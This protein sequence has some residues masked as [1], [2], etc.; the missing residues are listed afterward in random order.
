MGKNIDLIQILFL[1]IIGM[2]IPLFF[3]LFVNFGLDISNIQDLMK[4]LST[5][6]YFLLFFAIELMIV[7]IY[8]NLT[9]KLAIK[10]LKI[11]KK[12]INDD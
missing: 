1:V 2:F 9:N 6:G 4:I 12:K 3:S 7:F 11:K 5:F 10:K 8:F